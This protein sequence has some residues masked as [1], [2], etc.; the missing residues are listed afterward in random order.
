MDKKL[1][2]LFLLVLLCSCAERVYDE[3]SH[4]SD[5]QGNLTFSFDSVTNPAVWS[6]FNSL[7]EM[8]AACQIPESTLKK[9]TTDQLLSACMHYPLY[10][11]YIAYNNEMDGINAI[12]THFNGFSELSK[13]PDAAEKIL[14]LYEK[15][16]VDKVNDNIA[17][18]SSQENI[19]FLRLGYLELIIASKNFPSLYEKKI[20]FASCHSSQHQYC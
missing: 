12:I 10:G 15:V 2:Y 14:T 13:R 6:T 3:D 4:S 16:D 11:N 19:S 20:C 9:M 17:S 8:Q 1:I 7:E 18:R 5:S